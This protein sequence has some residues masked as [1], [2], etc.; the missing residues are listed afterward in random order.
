M[1]PTQPNAPSSLEV[2]GNRGGSY[3]RLTEIREGMVH[4]EV[5]ETC[6]RTIDQEI[7]VAALAAILTW[8]SDQGFQS[9]LDQY[10]RQPSGTPAIHLDRDL[11]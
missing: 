4:I 3:I 1:R 9:I 7:S 8:A 5:G 2:Q 6:V 11:P 10:W